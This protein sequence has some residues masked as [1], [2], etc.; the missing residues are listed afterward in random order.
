MIFAVFL[1]YCGDLALG[2]SDSRGLVVLVR[3]P[4]VMRIER[5]R[6]EGRPKVV[7]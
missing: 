5:W 2:D 1:R 4:Q 6:I 3:D 7:G